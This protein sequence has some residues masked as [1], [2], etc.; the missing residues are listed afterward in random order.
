VIK[1]FS[2]L[3]QFVRERDMPSS[4]YRMKLKKLNKERR[5]LKKQ[6]RRLTSWISR[7]ETEK[8]MEIAKQLSE[9]RLKYAGLL[10]IPSSDGEILL[11]E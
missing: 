10:N 3:K 1:S 11:Y 8:A 5:K 4:V 7:L 9:T 2:E 6:V